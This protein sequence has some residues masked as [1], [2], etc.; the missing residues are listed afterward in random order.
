MLARS[1]R[2]QGRIRLA[3]PRDIAALAA[4]HVASWHATYAGL[5]APHNLARIE[6]ER[7]KVRFRRHFWHDDDSLLHVLELPAGLVGYASSGSAGDL[8]MRGEVYELYLEPSQRGRG[9]GRRLLSNALWTLSGRGQNPVMVWVLRD[10]HEAR[11][12]YETLGGRE[13]GEGVAKFGDQRLAKVAYG[14]VDYLPWPED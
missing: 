1:R 6:L 8:G 5:I 4:I 3:E 12:F 10:N 2:P 11:C 14:W 13:I 9:Y 7:T